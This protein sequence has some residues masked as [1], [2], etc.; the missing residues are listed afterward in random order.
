MIIAGYWPNRN[1]WNLIGTHPLLVEREKPKK[2]EPVGQTLPQL[3]WKQKRGD[4]NIFGFLSSNFMTIH[5]IVL[6]LFWGLEKFKMAAVAMVTKVQNGHQIQKSSD[7]GEIWFSS[8]LS[9][10]ELIFLTVNF[11]SMQT[12][13]P[14]HMQTQT[15]TN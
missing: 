9:C 15:L 1:W 2:S 6:Q 13:I 14:S 12:T 5:R 4:L 11:I 7:L 10:C 8:R 3:P